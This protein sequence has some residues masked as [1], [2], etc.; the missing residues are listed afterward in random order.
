[1]SPSPSSPP[2]TVGWRMLAPL[3]LITASGPVAMQM[4]LPAL[5][6]LRDE[7]HASAFQA[8]ATISVALLTFG[9]SMLLWGP[10]SDR[11][12]RRAPL[13]V[14]VVLFM[15]GNVV[16]A[17][18]PT[19]EIFLAGR[20][21]NALGGA[22][23][24]VLTRAMVRDVAEPARV[25]SAMS[26]LTVG[27]IVP[28]MMAPAVG[29]LL[30]EAFGWRMNFFV[31]TGIGVITLLLA[32]RLPETHHGRGSGGSASIRG[33][34]GG[35][36]T[37][38]RLP[39]FR[40]Y[41]L[42]GAAAM[43]AY[44]AF[45]SG[46]PLVAVGALGMAPSTYGVAFVSISL[47]FMAGNMVSARVSPRLGIDRM[48]VSGAVC[49]LFGAALAL[50]FALAHVWEPLALFGPTMLVA[51]GNGLSLNNAQAGAMA[52]DDRLVG[53]AAGLMGFLQMATGAAVSQVVGLAYNGTPVPMTAVMAVSGVLAM[54]FYAMVRMSK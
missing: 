22:A 5:S 1:M 31:L 9:L 27:Q 24:M 35:F 21:L 7:L 20:A 46:A 43:G 49:G 25:A 18:A 36:G 39:R 37:L 8:Q 41:A 44:F 38:L 16:C 17:L 6:H 13:I 40:G 51:F 34:V 26:M 30:T 2:R 50:A 10:A 12:G 29:G 33:L 28:P 4:F 48:V 15:A 11:F 52:A 47:S 42:F 54:G 23:G 53:A 14:G 32:L 3:V 45:L 19:I